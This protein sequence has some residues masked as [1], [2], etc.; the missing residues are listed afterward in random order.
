MQH[1]LWQRE[2]SANLY[3]FDEHL[4][5]E[6]NKRRTG[7]EREREQEK[8]MSKDWFKLQASQAFAYSRALSQDKHTACVC[9]IIV[10]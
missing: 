5:R 2:K 10:L 8:E 1:N 4:M 3:V 9:W 6:E 7:G